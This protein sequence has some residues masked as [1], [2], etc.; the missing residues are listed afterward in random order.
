MAADQAQ[1][2]RQWMQRQESASKS[3]ENALEATSPTDASASSPTESS[4]VSP[5]ANQHTLMVVGLGDTSG[6]QVARVRQV[7]ERWASAGRH[8]VADP[9]AWRIVPIMADSPDLPCLAQ[10]QARW[11]LWVDDDRQAFRRAHETLKLLQGQP[12][13]RQMILLHA[14]PPT[15]GLVPNVR[16]V[17]K[18]VFDIDLLVVSA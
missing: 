9:D 13:P 4:P 17:A 5:P 1:G 7:L 14:A 10:H 3:G 2:L 18:A 15:R 16:A 8:W 11:G 12:V 6:V